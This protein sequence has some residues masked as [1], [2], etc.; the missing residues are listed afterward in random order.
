MIKLI[1]SLLLFLFLSPLVFFSQENIISEGFGK[2]CTEAKNDAFIN[3][4]NSVSGSTIFSRKDISDDIL[5]SEEISML[6]SGNII[7]YDVLKPCAIL[8]GEYYIKLK[9]T[10]SKTELKKFIEGKGKSVAI[11]GELLKQKSDQ[12]IIATKTELNIIENLLLQLTSLISDPFDYEINP[13]K[14]T[15]KDGKYCNLPIEITIKTNT[16]IQNIYTRLIREIE[17]I[18][19]NK[20]DQNFR[21][22]TLTET[23]YPIRINTSDFYLRNKKS[24]DLITTFY[25]NIITNIDNYVVVDGCLKEIYFR[26]TNQNNK[27]NQGINFPEINTEVA[28]IN[29]NYTT[30]IEEIG[31]LDRINIFSRDK[32]IDYQ[33]RKS[34]SNELVLMKYSETNPLEFKALNN[35]LLKKM[36]LLVHD[37]SHGKINILYSINFSGK[38]IN[39]SIFSKINTSKKSYKSIL[40]KSIYETKLNPSKLC[41][42]YT[43]SSDS[44]ILNVKWNTH[45][46]SYV[47]KN[48]SETQY[49]WFFSKSKLPYGVYTLTTKETTFNNEILKDVR[50]SNYRS[51]GLFS[52]LYSV[53]LPGWGTRRVTYNEKK[54]WGRFWAVVTPLTLSVAS[55]AISNDYYN[56]YLNGIV[57]SD[58]NQ[59]YTSA[60]NWNKISYVLG[61]ISASF[62]IYDIIWVLGKGTKN[63]LD[64]KSTKEN[65]KNSNFQ[66][67]YESIKYE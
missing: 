44:I 23:N 11:S 35:N 13:G 67:E 29:G 60:N 55:K 38:G 61:G 63:K 36:N 65:I 45:K 51:R 17:K 21:T 1:L 2:T 50:I 16:N 42:K 3:A 14:I 32:L 24:V 66:I 52:A 37:N 22:Q 48:E 9:V 46:K 41:G 34:I 4:I 58:I 49:N 18:A 19:L 59:N 15:I 5:I 30:T 64:Q 56:R 47:Y 54:G 43:P 7:S 27:L 53:L 31:S 8:N 10:V 28:I 62:Y 26:E 25:N 6:T 20:S 39:N 40:E 33:K 57:V 12:E